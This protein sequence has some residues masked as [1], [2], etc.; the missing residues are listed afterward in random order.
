MPSEHREHNGSAFAVRRA[1]MAD[2]PAIRRVLHNVRLEYGVLDDSGRADVDLDDLNGNYF[3]R[4]GCFEVIEDAD[5]RIVGCAGLCPLGDGRAE[6]CKMYIEKPARGR[7]LGKRLLNDMLD[8]ARRSGFS[9]VWLETNSTLSEAI[10][11][12]LSH[13][14]VPVAA[15]ADRLLSSC[16]QAYVL[17]LT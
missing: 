17:R 1:N 3:E 10:G 14:F 12:Y 8:A 13:G 11:L 4:G 9:E 2:L 6:L 15:D 16:D 5:G 7:G